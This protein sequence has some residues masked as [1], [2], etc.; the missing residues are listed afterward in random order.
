MTDG[1]QKGSG[2]ADHPRALRIVLALRSV[3]AVTAVSALMFVLVLILASQP[4]TSAWAAA[5]ADRRR[6]VRPWLR[7]LRAAARILDVGA[8]G[9]R[10]LNPLIS[11]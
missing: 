4:L 11:M 1:H 5:R 10:A 6:A 9:L 3:S 7:R 2:L 8:V